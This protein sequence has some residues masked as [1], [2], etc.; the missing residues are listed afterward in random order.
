MDD[1]GESLVQVI[2]LISRYQ[3]Q[4]TEGRVVCNMYPLATLATGSSPGHNFIFR[5][6]I[7]WFCFSRQ[8]E[9]LCYSSTLYLTL[10]PSYYPWPNLG[11][12]SVAGVFSPGIVVFKNDLDHD[13]VELPTAERVVVSVITVAAPRGPRLTPDGQRFKYRSELEDLRGKIRLV[14]RMAAHNGQ[15][16]LVLGELCDARFYTKA[17]YSIQAQWAAARTGAPPALLPKR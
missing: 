8:E 10:K 4:T 13:C 1:S 2:G 9:A 5:L 16:Y 14:Y 17:K 3:D 7:P 11:P 6:F 12:G 15:Q